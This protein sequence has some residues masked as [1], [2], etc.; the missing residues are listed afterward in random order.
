[1]SGLPFRAERAAGHHHKDD[2]FS[3]GMERLHHPGLDG[4]QGDRRTIAAVEAFHLYRHLLPFEP[5][6][7][8]ADEYDDIGVLY[9]LGN[10]LETGISGAIRLHPVHTAFILYIH[11]WSRTP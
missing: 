1:M 8:P 2:R 7:D 6:A 3:G 4:R 11:P 5:G 9:A 10:S